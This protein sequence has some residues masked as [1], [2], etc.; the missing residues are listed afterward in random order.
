MAH[1]FLAMRKFPAN[2][3]QYRDF[4]GHR[5]LLRHT[6]TTLW[7]VQVLTGFLLFFLAT[8]HLYQMLLH[9]EAIGPHAS[10]ARRPE[11]RLGAAL[12]GADGLRRAARRASAS[13]GSS[14]SGA[15]S[16][17]ADPARTRRRL[18]WSPRRSS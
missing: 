4:V 11:R 2:Y 14:S 16:R 13:T 8:P 7:W 17:A 15:G 3:R 12:P 9:P 5:K 18:R 10:A 1:A 6:D